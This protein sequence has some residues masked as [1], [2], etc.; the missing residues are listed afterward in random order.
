M[1]TLSIRARFTLWYSVMMAIVLTVFSSGVLWLQARWTHAQFESELASISETLS[2]VLAEELTET[3]D[4]QKATEEMGSAMEVTG[5]TTAVLRPDGRPVS[6]HWNGFVYQPGLSNLTAADGRLVTMI[7]GGSPWRALVTRHPAPSGDYLI[8]VAGELKRVMREQELL[9]RLLLLAT[10]LV[11]LFAA[12]TCWWL[13]SSALRPV[14]AMAAQADAL[15]GQSPDGR[16]TVPRTMDEVGL[17]GRSFNR[18]LERLGTALAIQRGFMAD[19]SHELRTPVS[20]VRTAAEVTLSHVRRDESEYRDALTIVS[21]QSVRLTRMV[22]D[23]LVMARADADAYPVRLEPLYLDDLVADCFSAAM[24]LAEPRKIRMTSAIH[25]DVATRADDALLRQ[26]LTNLLQNALRYTPDGGRVHVSL[27]TDR[28]HA[29]IAVADT[30][31]G[32]P[33]ADRQRVFDRFVR[34]DP[35]RSDGSGAGLGLP[36]VRWITHQHG[37]VVTVE[38][39]PAGVGSLFVVRLPLIDPPSAAA[40]VQASTSV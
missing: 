37:G 26:L 2:R 19:A 11:V 29:T 9:S 35:A 24:V 12:G 31:C 13:A 20:V 28:R 16:L 18:L 40:A 27:D 10:P 8:L 22:E 39:N 34:L 5:W 25:P 7:E 15:T 38:D 4:L 14:T 21:E 6:A 17:L 1:R 3:G 32:I 23:M 36:I 30:G 33:K